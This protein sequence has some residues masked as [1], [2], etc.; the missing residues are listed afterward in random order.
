M[1]QVAKDYITWGE[2]SKETL[3]KM[4]SV[5]GRTVGDGSVTEE[6]LKENSHFSSAGE[7]AE[8]QHEHGQDVGR[9]DDP[10]GYELFAG[11]LSR[12]SPKKSG[13]WKSGAGVPTGFQLRKCGWAVLSPHL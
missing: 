9:E 3:S 12:S 2:V 6:F 1:L 4:I 8:A 7:L 10:G 13:R 11:H 5:R